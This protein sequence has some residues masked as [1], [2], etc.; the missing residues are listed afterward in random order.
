MRLLSYAMHCLRHTIEEK[1]LGAY[2]T[3]MT[4]SKCHQLLCFRYC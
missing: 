4:V 3:A 2:L 1:C